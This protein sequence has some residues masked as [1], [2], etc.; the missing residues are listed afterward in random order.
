MSLS[1]KSQI[2]VEL[3]PEAARAHFSKTADN[4]CAAAARPRLSRRRREHAH[5]LFK[6]AQ[7]L[8]LIRIVRQFLRQNQRC[9][10]RTGSGSCSRR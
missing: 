7:H 2:G 9:V 4:R 10:G 1:G 8:L 3:Y 6:K 5:A